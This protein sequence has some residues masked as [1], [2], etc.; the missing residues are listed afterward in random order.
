MGAAVQGGLIAGVEVGPVLVDITPHTLGIE[1][2]GEL[3]G[4]PSIHTFAPIIERN[5]PLPASR[6][7]IF[8]TVVDGQK[9]AEIRVFQGEDEDTRYNT[10]V[11][12][13][14]IEGLADVGRGQSDP[15]AARPRPQRHP[16]GDRHRA[17]H[18]PG[19]AR[20]DRQRDGT[21]P[22]DS[23]GP[24]PSIAWRRSS[25]PPPRPRKR[26]RPRR[27][28][29]PCLPRSSRPSRPPSP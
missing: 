8:S 7:E 6:T 29:R 20:D 22:D 11:G 21:V 19:A 23:S 27:R 4:L 24:T 25:A 18:G 17:R 26:P 16:E 15:G 28:P 14:K 1:A 10:L 12:E 2:L 9:G 13:F 3:H 5:T